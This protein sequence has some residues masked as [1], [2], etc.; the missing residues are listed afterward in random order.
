M[1][2]NRFRALSFLI[3]GVLGVAAPVRAETL[4]DDLVFYA[5][6]DKS[7]DAV[8]AQGDGRLYTAASVA[9]AIARKDLQIGQLPAEV[10]LQADGGKYGGALK[11]DDKSSRVLVYLGDAI[12]GWAQPTDG[13]IT[14]WS[15][16]VSFWLKL[17]P[18]QDL[19][20][21]YCDPIQITQHA[22]NNAALFVDFDNTAERD[23]RL[24]VFSDIAAWN[25][26]NTPWEAF[27]VDKRP[28][29][30]VKNSPFTR[31]RWTHVAL[32]FDK[33]NPNDGTVS[34]ATLF[35]NGKSQGKLEGPMPFQC[36]LTKA[37]VMIGVDYIGQ[38]D[39]LTVFRRALT[40]EEIRRIS[41]SQEPLR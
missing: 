30:V 28:M 27:P 38:L 32:T 9:D 21:G 31:D 15:G 22:W 8:V 17:D 26:D 23:F 2:T 41:L 33:L 1:I 24:G 5:N 29:V 6:F 18:K 36:D 35:L 12:N 4:T 13:R 25:P 20:P 19:K 7:P 40:P 39:E 34:S 3:L 14:N 16:T 11:F 37:I 10:R